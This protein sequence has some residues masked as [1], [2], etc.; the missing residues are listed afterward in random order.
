[1]VNLSRE[2]E[3]I[4]YLL[5]LRGITR[6]RLTSY[7]AEGK[8]LPGSI[9]HLEVHS[10]S[11]YV[12]TPKE[13]YFIWL[14]WEQGHYTLVNNSDKWTPIDLQKEDEDTQQKI[15]KIQQE[16]RED[17]LIGVR[18]LHLLR[19]EPRKATER[20]DSIIGSRLR[21][22]HLRGTRLRRHRFE[23]YALV[24][25][26]SGGHDLVGSLY[27]GEV[28]DITAIL[29][30]PYEICRLTLHWNWEQQCY[31]FGEEAGEF[32]QVQREESTEEVWNPVEKAQRSLREKVERETQ[33]QWAPYEQEYWELHGE[34]PD[35]ETEQSFWESVGG[36]PIEKAACS[37]LDLPRWEEEERIR[38]KEH[39]RVAAERQAKEE[40]MRQGSP[41]PRQPRNFNHSPQHKEGA[42]RQ[43]P[44]Q[45]R[46]PR[47]HNYPPQRHAS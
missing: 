10:H 2:E 28:Q 22:S 42:M 4:Q 13:A 11:A 41:P 35:K 20:E 38:Q 3:I 39:A 32:R 7:Y 40:A 33:E 1:M 47:K 12:V 14:D 9:D 8:R 19:R 26:H 15:L 37:V 23:N 16:M 6:Y 21:G 46:V 25:V 17:P 45:L 44:P 43:A 31:T 24:D 30:M 29:V 18:E 5:S 27:P 34:A 36:S